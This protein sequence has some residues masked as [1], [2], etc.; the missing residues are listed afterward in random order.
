MIL[1][2]VFFFFLISF[3]TNGLR[4]DSNTER[5]RKGQNTGWVEEVGILDSMHDPKLKNR[6]EYTNPKDPWDLLWI[7][8]NK[9]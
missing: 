5:K 8:D 6:K 3:I 2:I 1:C 9:Q 7:Q 4:F